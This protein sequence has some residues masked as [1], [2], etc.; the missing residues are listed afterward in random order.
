M[1]LG[2]LP[3]EPPSG[4]EVK[5]GRKKEETMPKLLNVSNHS[6][7]NW[8]ESQKEGWGWNIIDV[9]FPQIDPTSSIEEVRGKARQL[10][11]L[12]RGHCNNNDTIFV[13]LQGEFTFCYLTLLELQKERVPVSLA[14]PTTERKVVEEK[15]PD[16]SVKKSSI[17]KFVQWRIIPLG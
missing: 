7:H 1:P 6:F 13:M 12:I 11:T 5:N 17:F 9:P 14:I 15:L 4:G 16:G 8:E 10:V 2:F 3:V